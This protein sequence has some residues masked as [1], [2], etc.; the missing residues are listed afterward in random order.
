M[1]IETELAHRC[2]HAPDQKRGGRQG[3]DCHCARSNLV[4]ADDDRADNG[5]LADRHGGNGRKAALQTVEM[6]GK[7]GRVRQP[8][9]AAQQ[10]LSCVEALH[11][12]AG[13]RRLDK[14]IVL[15]GCQPGRFTHT[16][17]VEIGKN[18]Q[19]HRQNRR[20][21][22]NNGDGA[23]EEEKKHCR[24]DEERKI[25]QQRH[26]N[27]G[28]ELRHAFNLAKADLQRSS[29]CR[30]GAGP[31]PQDAGKIARLDRRGNT[32]RDGVVEP[33]A[34]SAQANVDAQRKRDA[35]GERP[36]GFHRQVRNN[37]IIN[38]H[39]KQWH[40]KQQEVAH[41]RRHCQL[42]EIALMMQAHF[43]EDA[44][45][46]SPVTRC[47]I[48][49][50]RRGIMGKHVALGPHEE[51]CA[52]EKRLQILERAFVH[53]FRRFACKIASLCP[54]EQ[55]DAAAIRIQNDAGEIPRAQ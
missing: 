52:G 14:N 23:R 10:M 55:G 1:Q 7:S 3:T 17:I 29:K 36:Q 19:A 41:A 47:Q 42:N 9:P 51:N 22:W 54:P 50:R 39:R 31:R 40:G 44:A 49:G 27:I 13:R 5:R 16:R 53:P 48:F 45:N 21:P 8:L 11:G 26:H 4:D 2:H 24:N 15:G 38:R 6:S 35:N 33:Q 46:Q 37:A 20:R 12:F 25:N 43:V 32:E 28:Q 30:D 34:R 18:L